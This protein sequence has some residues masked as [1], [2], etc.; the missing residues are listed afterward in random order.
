MI[1]ST[2][3]VLLTGYAVGLVSALVAWMISKGVNG[4]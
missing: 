1:E 3:E 2:T 4:S